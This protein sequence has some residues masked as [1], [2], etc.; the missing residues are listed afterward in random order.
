MKCTDVKHAKILFRVE[1]KIDLFLQ[2]HYCCYEHD[3]IKYFRPINSC[4]FREKSHEIF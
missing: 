4:I 1:Q 2:Y 3:G